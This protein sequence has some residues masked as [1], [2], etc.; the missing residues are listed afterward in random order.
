MKDMEKMTISQLSIFLENTDGTLFKV[1]DV[2]KDAGI[3][4]IATTIADTVDYGICRIVCDYPMRAVDALRA[5]GLAVAV[6]DVFAL[7]MENRP[8]AA[9]D[10]LRL[11][12]DAGLNL[13]YLYSFTVSDRFILI[14]R[15]ENPEKSC[16]IIR[17][18][19]IS[20]LTDADMSV[21]V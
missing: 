11:F 5:A 13:P 16:E 9:V 4:I 1:L 19:K 8:G 18:E 14:I 10:V 2:L 12:K 15:S 20:Y 3:Q 17:R 21:L 6:T 7:S